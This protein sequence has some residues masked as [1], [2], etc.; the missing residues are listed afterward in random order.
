MPH[1]GAGH[2]REP[3][4]EDFR[5]AEEVLA[6]LMPALVRSAP[7]Y[8]EKRRALAAYRAEVGGDRFG[9]RYGL[10]QPRNPAEQAEADFMQGRITEDQ[11]RE[12]LKADAERPIDVAM[13]DAFR[14]AY[15]ERLL[16]YSRMLQTVIAIATDQRE[17]DA[18][19]RREAEVDRH[20]EAMKAKLPLWKEQLATV[21]GFLAELQAERKGEP[22]RCG[23]RSAESAHMLAELV[24]DQAAAGWRSSKEIAHR[25][26]TD[27]RYLYAMS[28]SNLFHSSHLPGLPR[29]QELQA[30]MVLEHAR[31]RKALQE[32]ARAAKADPSAPA[33]VSIQAEAV[34][35]TTPSVQVVAAAGVDKSKPK[36]RVKRDV[37][38]GLILQHLVRRPHDTA[39]EVAAAVGCSVGLVA[40]SAAW[41]ANRRRLEIAEKE[42]RDPKAVK[43]DVR[44]VTEVGG[45]KQAQMH[46]SREAQ[47]AQDAEID[48]REKELFRRIG[49]YQAKHPDAAPQEV[50]R[51]LGCTA[52][53]VER[54]QAML[55]RL[56]A[57]QAESAEEEDGAEK[58]GKRKGRPDGEKRQ[59]WIRR[60]V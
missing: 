19:R 37:A 18:W 49:E 41:R 12:M 7:E 9:L 3:S 35:V 52:G 17:P 58:F 4:G 21:F 30:L 11:F 38:E 50:A 42:G 6:L 45:G 32:Q 27:P 1:D 33:N 8:E 47:E 60:Q 46:A 26:R 5:A 28:A 59:K 2:G 40:E 16:A 51:A 34:R 20:V 44:A 29:P 22:V 55:E 39:E 36:G 57:D 10:R 25:S 43:L 15:E 24:M 13:L 14:D 54:R 31:A 53:D 23:D 48:A 56:L